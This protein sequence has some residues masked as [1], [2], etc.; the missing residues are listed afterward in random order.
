LPQVRIEEHWQKVRELYE[1]GFSLNQVAKMANISPTAARYRLKKMGVAMR[2]PGAAS[3]GGPKLDHDEIAR[4]VFLYVH[5]KLNAREVA[6]RTGLT[7]T[8]VQYRLRKAGVT[9]DVSDRQL[10]PRRRRKREAQAN[11]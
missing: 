10:V 2:R 8:G 5:C 3:G 6:E 4:C 9:R 1:M 11:A 7:R